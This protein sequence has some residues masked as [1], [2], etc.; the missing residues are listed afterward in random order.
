MSGR[1]PL[2]RRRG[3]HRQAI[4]TRAVE[5][6]DREGIEQVS[7]RRLA[8]ELGVTPM[9]FYSHVRDKSDLLDAM[10]EAILGE[11]ELPA[12]SELD[13]TYK[14]RQGLQAVYAAFDRHPSTGAVL[15]RPYL[16]PA[17]MRLLESWLTILSQAGFSAEESAR[18][19]QALT[20]MI[21]GGVVLSSAYGHLA[22]QS[23]ESARQ[24]LQ[25][26]TAFTDAL[27]TGEYPTLMSVLP[28]F[29]D[30]GTGVRQRDLTIELVVGGLKAVAGRLRASPEE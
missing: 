8:T 25:D 12:A 3:L 4:V 7:F 30:W 29:L 26:Y 15:A 2:P 10:A 23:E 14:L 28:V 27:P 24:D 5:I 18:L 13:W 1:S 9:A 21:L 6:A 16:S 11:I 22:G 19:I 20:A 17:S